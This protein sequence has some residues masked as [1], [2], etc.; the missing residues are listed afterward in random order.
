MSSALPM[1]KNTASRVQSILNEAIA[2]WEVLQ[3][4]LVVDIVD[5]YDFVCEAFEQLLV[6]RQLKY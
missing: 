5:L 4:I 6:Q 3:Q 2:G 1:N